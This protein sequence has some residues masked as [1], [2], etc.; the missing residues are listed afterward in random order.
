MHRTVKL[1]EEAGLIDRHVFGD[2]CVRYEESGEYH[3]HLFDVETGESIEFYHAEQKVL[4]EQIASE[5]GSRLVEHR[6][7]LF[8][9][10][11]NQNAVN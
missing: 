4:K 10:K 7:E 5:M 2:G 6:L 11:I 9:R 1:L 8:G 3:E